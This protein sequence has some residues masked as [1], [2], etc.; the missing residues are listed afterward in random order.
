MWHVYI[1]KCLDNSLYT[2][3]ATDLTRRLKEHNSNKGG[4]YTRVRKPVELVY[5]EYCSNRSKAQ[6]REAQIKGWTRA[7]K[8]CLIRCDNKTLKNLS[9]LKD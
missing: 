2:G 6:K 9:K 1:L 5:K 7:K 3:S 8:L 4:A